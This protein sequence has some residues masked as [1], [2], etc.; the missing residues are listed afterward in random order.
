MITGP[1]AVRTIENE[2]GSAKNDNMIIGPDAFRT[3]ENESG[4]AK[5]E[6]GSDTLSTA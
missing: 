4:S 1:D 2:F 5:K 3:P 6:N